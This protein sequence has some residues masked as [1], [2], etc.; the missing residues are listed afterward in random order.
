MTLITKKTPVNVKKSS[1]IKYL[2]RLTQF[3]EVGVLGILLLLMFFLSLSTGN[4][5]SIS[6][7]LGIARQASFFGMM[8]VGLVC[9]IAQGDIDLS[10]ASIYNLVTMSM[11]LALYHGLSV[12]LVLF[13]GVF[14]GILLGFI[15]GGLSVLLKIPTLIVTLGTMTVYSGLS[16]VLGNGTSISKFPKDNWFFNSLS[17][18]LFD[19]IP[20]S[21][22]LLMGVAVIGFIL[23]NQTPYGRHICAIGSNKQAA[24]YAGIKV[25]HYRI[26]TMMFCGFCCSI[27]GIGTFGYLQA[28][29][30]SIGKGA[31]MM[32]ISASIIGGA[33]LSGG[34]G[35]IIGAVIGALLIAVI[36]NGMVLLGVSI[37]MQGIVTGFVII[38][39]VAL[40]YIIKRRR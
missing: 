28:A 29:D 18:K 38:L 22:I 17:G 8:A 37:Y 39:A 26:V 36:R 21:V 4:F 34:T 2:V 6:N 9:V 13:V 12:N 33:S 25:N 16:L 11:G 15:N 14:V 10:V 23:F 19:V 30:P 35:S 24:S 3:D 1:I 32:A 27:A 20:A 5:A 7:L 31:E 40:D